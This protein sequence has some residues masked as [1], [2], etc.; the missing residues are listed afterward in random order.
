VS[1]KE[2]CKEQ[3]ELQEHLLK[4]EKRGVQMEREMRRRTDGEKTPEPP[5][6]TTG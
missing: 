4:L 1:E 5:H 3:K 6:R 2:V